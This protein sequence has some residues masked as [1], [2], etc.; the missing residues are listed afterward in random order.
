MSSST[1]NGTTAAHDYAGGT[2]AELTGA[3]S[4]PPAPLNIVAGHQHGTW[5][6]T[7]SARTA[8]GWFLRSWNRDCEVTSVHRP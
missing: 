8:A 3:E 4:N 5:P 1:V 6:W 7:A 2:Q